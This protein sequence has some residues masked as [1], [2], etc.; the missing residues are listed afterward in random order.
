MILPDLITQQARTS[1]ENVAFV[2]RDE[3]ITF[4]AL[5]NRVDRCAAKLESLGIKKGTTFAIVL[6][7]SPE[8]VI[9][10]MALSKLGA[11]VIPINFLEKADRIA[12]ILNDAK[13]V[14]V[15]TGKEFL[16]GVQEAQKNVPTLKHVFLRENFSELL[17]EHPW[18]GKTT[19]TE[20]DLMMLLY[21]S[22]TTGAPKGV[23]LTHKNFLSNVKQCLDAISLKSS[24]KFLCLLPMFH[25]FSWTT[26]VLIPLKL[27]APT[28]IIETLLPFDPVLSAIWKHHITLFVA[29]PQIYSALATKIS[30]AKAMALRLVN[31]V[32]LC[33]SGSAPLTATVHKNFEKNLGVPLLEGYGLTEASPVASLNPESK[34]KVGTV[35]L[36]LPGVSVEIRDENGKNMAIGEIGE[37]YIKGD[38]VTK[39]YYMKPEETQAAL[40]SDGWLKTGDI[41]KFD[42]EGYLSIVDRKK[43]L[44]IIKGLNVY[45]QDVENVITMHEGVREVAVVGKPD[46]ETGDETIRA[47]ITV[48]EGKTIDKS[49]IFALC[50]E[51]LAPYKR[52][53]DVIFIDEMPKNA[54]QKILKKDLRERP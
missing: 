9:F 44:I 41:G 33:I 42:D 47:F 11:I 39:G 22:G 52:P 18:A 2:F 7:N 51:H 5:E 16:K 1:P 13:A 29:M 53:K 30:G 34:R 46:K 17:A 27:G 28:V 37:I 12:L 31:P 50:R 45:P 32:R 49:E 54:L 23:M 10:S 15:L 4:A 38:N 25:S 48:K 14:G 35:G 21:T 6:R 43:D 20:D 36:P 26:C 24:D 3:K 40:T 8:F 19:T